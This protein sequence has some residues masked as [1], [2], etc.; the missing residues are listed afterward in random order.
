MLLYH[1]HFN[2]DFAVVL[3]HMEGP[4]A[5]KFEQLV[6]VDLQLLTQLQVVLL[7]QAFLSTI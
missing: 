7:E 2:P 1:E 6:V 5:V 3:T 4:D